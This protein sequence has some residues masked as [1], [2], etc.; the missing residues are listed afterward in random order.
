MQVRWRRD[1]NDVG[2]VVAERLPATRGSGGRLLGPHPL[3]QVLQLPRPAPTTA[4]LTVY[5]FRLPA[6]SSAQAAG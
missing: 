4:V 2:H 6:T 3:A 1:V 5:T